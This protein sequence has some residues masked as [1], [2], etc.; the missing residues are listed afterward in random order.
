MAYGPWQGLCGLCWACVM[1][2]G[3]MQQALYSYMR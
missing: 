1:Q 2:E 3:L